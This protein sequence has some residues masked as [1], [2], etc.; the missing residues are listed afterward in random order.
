MVWS[1]ISKSWMSSFEERRRGRDRTGYGERFKK[2]EIEGEDPATRRRK[3]RRR[4]GGERR[5]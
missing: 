3:K 2:K 5:R 1:R 4:R